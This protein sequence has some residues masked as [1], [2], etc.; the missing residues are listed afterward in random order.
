MIE[1]KNLN[2]NVK[3]LK[4]LKDINIKFSK[5]DRVAIVGHN[6][7]G[8][9]ALI[10]TII[11][12]NK[13]TS[14]SVKYDFTY[15]KSPLE[16]IGIQFQDSN[17][18]VGLSVKDI[19][20][21]FSMIY[22]NI[23]TKWIQKIIDQ[24]QINKFYNR[25][26]KELSGGQRQKLNILLS[27]ILKPKILIFDELTTG[28]DLISRNLIFELI[29]EYIKGFDPMIL[30]VTHNIEEILTFCNRIIVMKNGQ[31]TKDLK[32]E[33]YQSLE[34]LLTSLNE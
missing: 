20:D 1:V 9:T 13:V 12:L 10:E 15:D 4:I 27:L 34:K 6:G 5:N 17:F 8:K 14:G 18:P 30:I 7:A 23:D 33:N 21:Y 29:G 11:H 26:A 22:Q 2:Y 28:L 24:L 16:K 25:N 31:I 32:V 19:I 3:N